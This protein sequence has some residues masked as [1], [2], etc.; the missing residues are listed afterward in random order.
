[1]ASEYLAGVACFLLIYSMVGIAENVAVGWSG[2]FSIAQGAVFGVG[3]VTYAIA[4]K[5]GY[6]MIAVLLGA[7]IAGGLVGGALAFIGRGVKGDFFAIATLAFQV[8]A[9]NFAQNVP[10]LGGFGGITG[11]PQIHLLDYTPIFYTQWLPLLVPI[12]AIYALVYF[13]LMGT[14][15]GIVLKAVREDEPATAAVGRRVGAFKVLALALSGIGTGLAGAIYASFIG[16]VD[17]SQFGFSFSLLILAG[18]LVGGLGN[19]LGP[20]AGL[21]LLTLLPEALRFVPLLPVDVRA[22]L[23]QVIYSLVLLLFVVFRPQGL[24]P[25]RPG[26]WSFAK[27]TWQ[28]RLKDD[29]KGSTFGLEQLPPVGGAVADQ[30]V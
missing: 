27:W 7:G 1:M 25:E 15:L 9:V 17:P 18:L 24:V 2:Q 19:P 21:A 11:V 8:V 3:A 30:E 5:A 4:I 20:I 10:A 16:Y 13:S 23:L 14:R 28:R 26:R 12:T 29:A 22:R 6:A